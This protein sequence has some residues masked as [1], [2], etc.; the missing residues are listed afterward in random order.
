[1]ISHQVRV[2]LCIVHDRLDIYADLSKVFVY[3]YI[4]RVC[5][6]SMRDTADSC[7]RLRKVKKSFKANQSQA[8]ILK[9][10][11][12]QG[13]GVEGDALTG[14]ESQCFHPRDTVYESAGNCCRIGYGNILVRH[15]DR[16][17]YCKHA[18]IQ[19]KAII[20]LQGT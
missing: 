3:V 15:R 12:R 5:L 11:R 18:L 16:A 17:N 10:A 1:M 14:H 19:H 20:L 9:C 2:L 13:S 7:E 8:E 4:V 6:S